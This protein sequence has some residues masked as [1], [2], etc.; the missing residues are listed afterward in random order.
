MRPGT[1]A[2]ERRSAVSSAEPGGGR[3]GDIGLRLVARHPHPG[4][5]QA[6]PCAG[7]H[8]G[9]DRRRRRSGRRRRARRC[10]SRPRARPRR[11]ARRSRG[12][13]GRFR[14]GPPHP[15]PRR[16]RRVEVRRRLVEQQET[17]THGER[18]GEREALLLPARE[19]CGRMRERHREPD[20]VERVA[21]R[22]ARSRRA[23]RRGSRSRTRHRRRRGPSRPATRDPAAPARPG[24]APRSARTRRQSALPSCSP[25]SSPPSTPASA[26]SSVDLPDP[27]GPSSSTRSPGSMTQVEVA[28]GPGPAARVPPAPAARPH[29]GGCG[30]RAPSC[31]QTS[32]RPSRP[33]AKRLSAPVAASARA[34]AHD[35]SP[36][37]TAPDTIARRCRS[38]RTSRP[39]RR[40]RARGR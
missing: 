5:R 17:R 26:C 32:A 10:A 15:G 33:A 11:G 24:R 40:T 9:R 35:P 21:A 13:A 16:P 7:E 29:R 19:L 37:M 6:A 2:I 14:T 22:A 27:E 3:R 25:S 34:S 39:L 38:W 1:R 4:R 12:R 18:A 23:E 30:A 36:A 31:D 28:Q 8:L 20:R